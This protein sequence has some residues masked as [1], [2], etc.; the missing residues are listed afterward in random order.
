M[1]GLAGQRVSCSSE[2]VQRRLHRLPRAPIA[3]RFRGQARAQPLQV[4]LVARPHA[5]RDEYEILDAARTEGHE[6]LI[7]NLGYRDPGQ[8]MLHRVEV[9][10]LERDLLANEV[11]FVHWRCC[12]RAL[13]GANRAAS[14]TTV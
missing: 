11:A 1:R 13:H 9:P 12:A 14:S 6:R 8:R 3:E 4:C 7:V 2:R 10:A 5:G